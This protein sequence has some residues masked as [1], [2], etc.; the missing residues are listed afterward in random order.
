M[1]RP[2]T[3]RSQETPLRPHLTLPLRAI[4]ATR[5]EARALRDGVW[6]SGARRRARDA[7]RIIVTAA[8]GLVSVTLP[9]RR[10]FKALG[11]GG[12]VDGHLS[13]HQVRHRMRGRR[14]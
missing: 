6:L 1:W 7:V 9:R 5:D 8:V 13:P 2:F 12:E 10:A 3:T 14:L 4:D 11:L